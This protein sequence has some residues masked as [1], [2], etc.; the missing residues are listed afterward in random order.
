[1]IAHKR[2]HLV[3]VLRLVDTHGKNLHAGLFLPLFVD[4]ADGVQ[5]AIAGLAPS[6]E[7][8]DD[9]GLAIVRKGIG[10]HFCAVH[11]LQGDGWQLGPNA[12]L[13]QGKSHE[14]KKYESFHSSFCFHF[15]RAKVRSF[16]NITLNQIKKFI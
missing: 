9:E 10:S 5:L 3:D 4:L 1:M 14:R 13:G 2:L 15:S 11:R 12:V 8:V 16:S 7:E 6:R